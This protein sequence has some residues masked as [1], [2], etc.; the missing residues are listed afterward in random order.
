[1]AV[2]L[3]VVRR[4]ET[5]N[6]PAA[7]YPQGSIDLLFDGNK[8]PAHPQWRETLLVHELAQYCTDQG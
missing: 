6:G 3:K 4:Q 2:D 8:A 5:V 7:V 1:M